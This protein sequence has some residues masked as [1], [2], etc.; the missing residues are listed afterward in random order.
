M[1]ILELDEM[2][3][4]KNRKILEIFFKNWDSDKEIFMTDYKL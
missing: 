3:K 1:A 2:D 4:I